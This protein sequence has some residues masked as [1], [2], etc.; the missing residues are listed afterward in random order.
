MPCAQTAAQKFFRWKFWKVETFGLLTW[1][2]LVGGKAKGGFPAFEARKWN[3]TT[4]LILP[5]VFAKIV[6]LF[7]HF[8][9]R[10]ILGH[11]SGKF[12]RVHPL[13][14]CPKNAPLSEGVSRDGA[15]GAGKRRER[16][17]KKIGEIFGFGGSILPENRPFKWRGIEGNALGAGAARE[18][19]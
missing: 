12:F 10:K 3:Y 15:L 18:N 2:P 8:L 4:F 19:L 14:F 9:L 13:R 11:N 5:T 7:A 16:R 6:P 17:K 1:L